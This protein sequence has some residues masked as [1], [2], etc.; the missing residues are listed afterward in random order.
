MNHLLIMNFVE[1][2]EDA[3]MTEREVLLLIYRKRRTQLRHIAKHFK[4][5]THQAMVETCVA[6]MKAERIL[7]AEKVR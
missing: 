1:T 2:P 7:A 5:T 3:P 6:G 4:I